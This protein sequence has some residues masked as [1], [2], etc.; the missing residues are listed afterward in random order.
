MT[1]DGSTM[2]AGGDGLSISKSQQYVGIVETLLK[3]T[4]SAQSVGKATYGSNAITLYDIK[5]NMI[6]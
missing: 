2:D 3:L 6:G 4:V 5:G 1:K